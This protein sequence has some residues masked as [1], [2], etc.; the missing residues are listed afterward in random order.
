MS[1]IFTP[2]RLINKGTGQTPASATAN[3]S[4]GTIVAANE[5]R[6]GI[7]LTNIGKND[8]WGSETEDA[9]ISAGWL[10]GKNGGNILLSA[11]LVGTGIIKAITEAGK[12]TTITYQEFNKS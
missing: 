5:N 6:V 8:A 1:I 9:V 7:L 2:P 4:S 12:S 10:L 3:D 11:S